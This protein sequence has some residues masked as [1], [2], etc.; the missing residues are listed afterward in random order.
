MVV[1]SAVALHTSG[2]GYGSCFG[3]VCGVWRERERE[4]VMVNAIWASDESSPEHRQLGGISANKPPSI[5]IWLVNTRECI[6]NPSPCK[7]PINPP[8]THTV[9]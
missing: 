5:L 7:Y 6:E 2:Q 3:F 4:R 8:P 9:Q 1:A